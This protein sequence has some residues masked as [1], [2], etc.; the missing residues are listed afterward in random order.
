M[1]KI[2]GRRLCLVLT[3][4][5]LSV[6]ALVGAAASMADSGPEYTPVENLH[7]TRA[8]CM[9]GQPYN[10]HCMTIVTFEWPKE[11]KLVKGNVGIVT[12]R[13]SS[14][15]PRRSCASSPRSASI[16]RARRTSARLTG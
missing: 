10:S 4:A 16:R 6:A 9:P 3:S 15:C 1:S 14:T 5:L 12:A 11:A 2:H 13:S 7:P 8:E